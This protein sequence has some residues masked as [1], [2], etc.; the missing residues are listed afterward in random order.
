LN[1]HLSEELKKVVEELDILKKEREEKEIR[2][3]A[4]AKRKRLPKRSP[5][6]REIYEQ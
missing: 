6:T 5:I 2:K 1:K 3:Q 4:R